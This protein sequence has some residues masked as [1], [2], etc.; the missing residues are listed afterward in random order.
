MRRGEGEGSTPGGN[1]GGRYIWSGRPLLRWWVLSG[2]W[3]FE[4][5]VVERFGGGWDWIGLVGDGGGDGIDKIRK[6]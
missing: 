2:G 5:V 4:V 6:R 3:V 1:G